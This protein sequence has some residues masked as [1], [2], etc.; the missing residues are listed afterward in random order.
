MGKT[1]DMLME[2]EANY[3]KEP[4]EQDLICDFE[5]KLTRLG[6][7]KKEIQKRNVHELRRCLILLA[8]WIAELTPDF[9]E[10]DKQK[11]NRSSIHP[12]EKIVFI[13]SEMRLSAL[14]RYSALI[15]KQ[16]IE[17][18]KTHLSLIADKKIRRKIETNL[19]QIELKDQIILREYHKSYKILRK[20]RS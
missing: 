20:Y 6:L 9:R 1:H 13:L 11:L 18:I 3:R 2:A 7:N 12:N 16:K 19:I 8:E 4:I 10:D 17:N 14:E 15:N 5:T